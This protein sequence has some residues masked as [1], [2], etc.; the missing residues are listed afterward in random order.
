[1][2]IVLYILDKLIHDSRNVCGY[3]TMNKMY[4][5]LASL[6][7]CLVNYNFTNT[8][9]TPPSEVKKRC[10]YVNIYIYI[11][12][13]IYVMYIIYDIYIYIYIYLYISTKS[14]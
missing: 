3:L 6:I 11:Y 8:S 12:I 4:I 9:S 10:L 2:E 7:I 1:M 5:K 13:Y 14:T